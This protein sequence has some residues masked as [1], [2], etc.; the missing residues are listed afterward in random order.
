MQNQDY[1]ITHL[2]GE[3]V[4]APLAYIDKNLKYQYVNPAFE[5]SFGTPA[6]QIV[7]KSVEEVLGA[8]IFH[9]QKVFFASALSGEKVAFKSCMP[10]SSGNSQGALISLKPDIG[11]SKE[12]RGFVLHCVEDVQHPDPEQ[13]F[14]QFADNLKNQVLHIIDFHP[15]A[16]SFVSNSYEGIC[17]RPIRR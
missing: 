14:L 5:L 12:V 7:G 10:N 6:E 15:P 9:Q 16:I 2:V 3:L 13:R 17:G 8:E 11:D 1:F 4:P